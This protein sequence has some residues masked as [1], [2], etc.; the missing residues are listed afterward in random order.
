MFGLLTF[1]IALVVVPLC[2]IAVI[3][4]VWQYPYL[5]VIPIGGYYLLRALYRRA[6]AR[7][8]RDVAA[9]VQAQMHGNGRGTGSV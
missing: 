2:A 5:I 9:L 3:S 8:D 4:G 6:K 7:F 1:L